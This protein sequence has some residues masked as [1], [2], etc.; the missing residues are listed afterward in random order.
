MGMFSWA[1]CGVIWDQGIGYKTKTEKQDN[2]GNT[3]THARARVQKI[4]PQKIINLRGQDT[5]FIN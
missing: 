3:H 4:T 1:V 5:L 2:K